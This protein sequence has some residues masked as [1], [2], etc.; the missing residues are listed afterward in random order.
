VETKPK[1][2]ITIYRD[3][4]GNAQFSDDIHYCTHL[5][6]YGLIFDL[7]WC[8]RCRL[9]TG[10]YNHFGLLLLLLDE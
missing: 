3:D 8:I 7:H 5:S 1:D 6:E 9:E 2:V 4:E 10:M